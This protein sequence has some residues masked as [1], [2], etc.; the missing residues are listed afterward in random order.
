[1]SLLKL[2]Q[3]DAFEQVSM[4]SALDCR[5]VLISCSVFS[6]EGGVAYQAL[7]ELLEQVKKSGLRP[8][9]QVDRLVEQGR[10]ETVLKLMLESACVC[11]VSDVGL[12]YALNER[13]HSFQLS[14]ES[15]HANLEAQLAWVS[16]LPQLER[17]CLNHQ[18]PKTHLFPMLSRLPVPAELFVM[19][20]L[21]MY[22]T[23]RSLLSWAGG[24]R[25]QVLIQA[26]DMGPGQY[27]LLQ[28]EAGTVM[29]YNKWLSLV[30]YLP[31][32]EEAGVGAVRFDL[33]QMSASD[34]E[35]LQAAVK[36]PSYPLK[37]HFSR[38]LLHGYYGDN[39]S[40]SIFS[41]LV[42]RRPDMEKVC[43]G[44][45]VDRSSS[46][47]LIKTSRALGSSKIL[48]AKDGK[49]RWHEWEV[50]CCWGALGEVLESPPEEGLVQI[51]KPRNFPVGTYLYF[52][53]VDAEM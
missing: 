41:K 17:L 37:A 31:E 26:E 29:R 49:G 30:P 6:R 7:P 15:G 36:D 20:P 8:I 4:A 18:I 16:R 27:E 2:A 39:R 1:M 32:L 50:E 14:L 48:Q 53:S 42:G 24:E 51:K 33:R 25:E 11:R 9:L 22:Y 46:R 28:S 10:F 13:G 43:W 12:A 3:I 35:H 34:F 21:A 45:V 23:P 44:E 19:G 38:P 40:D 47:L 5:E 52:K